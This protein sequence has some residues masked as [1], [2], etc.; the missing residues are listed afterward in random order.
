MRVGVPFRGNPEAGSLESLTSEPRYAK[1]L[2]WVHSPP[3]FPAVSLNGE[4]QRSAPPITSAMGSRLVHSDAQEINSS[5]DMRSFVD[6]RD[7][8]NAVSSLF[9]LK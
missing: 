1:F 5:I 8:S 4:D 6:N 3:N 2:D 7:P 9:L